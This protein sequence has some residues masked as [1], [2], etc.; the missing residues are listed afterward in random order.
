MQITQMSF[1][2][3]LF[4]I[5]PHLLNFDSI[6]SNLRAK[7]N[8]KTIRNRGEIRWEA[9]LN[10]DGSYDDFFIYKKHQKWYNDTNM[11]LKGQ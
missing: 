11:L 10:A 6:I 7:S 4:I 2:D 8:R 1:K 9:A 3:N 5:T